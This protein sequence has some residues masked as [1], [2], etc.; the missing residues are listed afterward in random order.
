MWLEVLI[1]PTNAM[2]CSSTIV[3]IQRLIQQETAFFTAASSLCGRVTDITILLPLYS[4]NAQMFNF[5]LQHRAHGYVTDR[6]CKNR[7]V[8]TTSGSFTRYLTLKIG[9][10]LSTLLY[11]WYYCIVK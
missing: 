4:I 7:F 11:L 2:P 10:A 3:S 9:K 6:K 5:M 1:V 8:E